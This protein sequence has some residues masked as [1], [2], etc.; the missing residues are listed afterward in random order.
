MLLWTFWCMYL[1][2]LVFLFFSAIYPGVK[3]LGHMVVLFLVFWETSILFHSGCTNLHFYQQ[4]RRFP[5]SS[6]PCQLSLFVF[7]LTIAI[8]AGERWY[9]IVVLICISLMMSDVVYLFVGLL[10]ICISSLEKCLFSSSAHFLNW[11]V[12]FFDVEFYEL[13]IY[14]GY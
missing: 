3:L 5:F 14:F 7:F 12:W 6:H 13:F 11:I 9:L 10:A 8:L 1:S 2:E 4:C